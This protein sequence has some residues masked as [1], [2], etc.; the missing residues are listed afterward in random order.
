MVNILL[1][2]ELKGKGGMISLAVDLQIP[3]GEC[4]AL[5]GVSGVGKTSILKMISGILKPDNGRISVEDKIWLDTQ[6]KINLKPQQRKIGYVFQ[7]Y[8]LFPNMSVRENLLYAMPKGALKTEIDPII[9]M[10]ELGDLQYQKPEQLSGGQQQRVALGR[11]VASKPK[12]LLLDEPLSALD[13][14]MRSKLQD[15]ILQ[16]HQEYKLTTILVSHDQNE[17]CRLAN[18]VYIIDEGSISTSGK[19]EAIFRTSEKPKMRLEGKIIKLKKEHPCHVILEVEG[20]AIQIPITDT[21][22]QKLKAGEL[23]KFESK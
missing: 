15:Y 9:D 12:L 6:Q 20:T 13:I 18:K 17:I 10:M 1:E 19:P 8:A 2:K 7:E 22:A 11:A 21:V 14:T 5:Y 3:K 23:L 4:I 16:I